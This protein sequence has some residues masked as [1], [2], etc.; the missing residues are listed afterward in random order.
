[1]TDYV[2]GFFIADYSN[3]DSSVDLAPL[4]YSVKSGIKIANFLAKKFETPETVHVFCDCEASPLT[5]AQLPQLCDRLWFYFIGHGTTDAICL[6]DRDGKLVVLSPEALLQTLEKFGASEITVTIDC[7]HSGAFCKRLATLL[8][9]NVHFD[10]FLLISS[11]E[12]QELA[13]EDPE[14]KFT[15][16]SLAMLESLRRADTNLPFFGLTPMLN[17]ISKSTAASAYGLKK[18]ARQNVVSFLSSHTPVSLG[19]YSALRR[20][21]VAALVSI[22]L[23]VTAGLAVTKGATYRLG[24]SEEGEV[25]I[26][27]GPKFLSFTEPLLQK[28]APEHSDVL[29]RTRVWADPGTISDR[30]ALFDQTSWGIRGQLDEN[31][32][33]SSLS[34]LLELTTQE[35]SA[36][37]RSVTL[38]PENDPYSLPPFLISKRRIV[39]GRIEETST[40]PSIEELQLQFPPCG[41]FPYSGADS[42]RDA[43]S[44]TPSLQLHNT[45]RTQFLSRG[46]IDASNAI[47]GLTMAERRETFSSFGVRIV[48]LP[49]SNSRGALSLTA[50]IKVLM[51]QRGRGGGP[52]ELSQDEKAAVIAKLAQLQSARP[53]SEE[54]SRCKDTSEHIFALMG[55]ADKD[56]ESDAWRDLVANLAEVDQPRGPVLRDEFGFRILDDDLALR[57]TV[58]AIERLKAISST[59]ELIGN[60]KFTDLLETVLGELDYERDLFTSSQS[61]LI[62]N[63]T[64]LA[65]TGPLPDDIISSLLYFYKEQLFFK[66]SPRPDNN[67]THL[68]WLLSLQAKSLGDEDYDLL[69]RFVS[70]YEE[71]SERYFEKNEDGLAPEQLQ[72]FHDDSTQGFLIIWANMSRGGGVPKNWQ[73][74]LENSGPPSRPVNFAILATDDWLTSPWSS[75]HPHIVASAIYGRGNSLTQLGSERLKEFLI[76]FEFGRITYRMADGS[77]KAKQNPVTVSDPSM[78]QA[79]ICMAIAHH[80]YAG[81]SKQSVVE[82]VMEKIVA[83]TN[84][85]FPRFSACPFSL[86]VSHHSHTEQQEFIS[87]L[88]QRWKNEKDWIVRKSIANVIL[89]TVELDQTN[90]VKMSWK[91]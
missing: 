64:D 26:L 24:I 52:P 8:E 18:G 83:E 71:E 63:L 53:S 81:L 12:A 86:W 35:A 54:L 15:C 17:S 43:L 72:Q 51:A 21:L 22:A 70:E 7:C 41:K 23:I 73:V 4:K 1:M 44:E 28:F 29:S 62:E 37:L 32:L 6:M 67:S 47:A 30:A 20:R 89:V 78:Q 58:P 74:L 19:F 65:L 46:S 82:R 60:A 11:T 77:L 3:I 38:L 33:A 50:T 75:T 59:G 91:P 68:L 49:W 13:W 48:G 90:V 79:S 39:Q 10:K 69:H 76:D 85:N 66:F 87:L 55:N 25:V 34:Q 61:F 88:R 31:A 42:M 14:L 5:L 56:F 40:W 84:T 16:F 9:N 57:P 27:R 2:F 80:Q 45:F 36:H